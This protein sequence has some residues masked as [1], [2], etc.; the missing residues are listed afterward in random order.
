MINDQKLIRDDFDQLPE[1]LA[2]WHA[3][4]PAMSILALVS[5]TEKSRIPALQQ[6]CRTENVPLNGAVFPTLLNESGFIEGGIWL[7]R[8]DTR[9]P[10]FLLADL[11]GSD[12]PAAERIV[13]ATQAMLDNAPNTTPAPTLFMLFDSMLPNIASMLTGVYRGLKRRVQ[14]AGINAGSESFQPLPCLFDTD[15]T[16]SNGLL[17]LLLP[18]GAAAAVDHGYPVSRSEMRA[19]STEG[20]R[21]DQINGRPA[22]EVYQEIIQ[23]EYGVALTQENFYDHAVHFPL[24]VVTAA[25]VLVRIPVAFGNDNSVSCVGEVPPNSLLRVLKAPNL[26]E[27]T[28]IDNITNALAKMDSCK[29]GAPLLTFYCAGRRMHFGQQ[30]GDEIAALKLKTGAGSVAG[31]LSLGEIDT[32]PDFGMPRFHNAAVVCLR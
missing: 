11:N 15:T 7:L 29:A 9:P 8:F 18:D 21:V 3:Q 1:L 5:E 2:A 26:V 4:H 31:A 6:I 28:C 23:A 14:Y 27:S 13:S 30:A 16:V 24:G 22:F 17:A 12:R 25:D 10:S 20:N 19:T 32:M